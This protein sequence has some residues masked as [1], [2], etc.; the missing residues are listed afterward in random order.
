MTGSI[1]QGTDGVIR[2]SAPPGVIRKVTLELYDGTVEEFDDGM[3]DKRVVPEFID[4]IRAINENDTAFASTMLEKSLAVCE[5][6]TKLRTGA[7]IVFP[8]DE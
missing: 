1:I 3:A 4:F 7:G 5:M 2:T 8:M 6:Q